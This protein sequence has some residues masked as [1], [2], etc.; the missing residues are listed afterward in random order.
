MLDL[1]LNS[2]FSVHLNGQHGLATVSGHEALEQAV[3]ISLTEYLNST[4]VGEFDE[5]TIIQKLKLQVSRVVRQE[6]S[7]AGLNFIE[8]EPDEEQ[9]NTYN[10]RIVFE[11]DTAISLRVSE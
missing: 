9:P 4:T 7:I 8:V 5:D 3:S 11:S 1:S 6:D 2:D 10:V